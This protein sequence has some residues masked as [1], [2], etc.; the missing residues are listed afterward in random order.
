MLLIKNA[1]ESTSCLTLS[2][3]MSFVHVYMELLV[4]PG[5]LTSYI[6]GPTYGS[7]ESRRFLFAA[8]CFNA[9]SIQKVILWHSS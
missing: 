1:Y 3:L 7:A 9:E 4:K 6:Y 8:Q 5:M 2:L